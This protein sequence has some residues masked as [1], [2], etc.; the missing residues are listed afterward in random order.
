[1]SIYAHSSW[2]C[3]SRKSGSRPMHASAGWTFRIILQLG[4]LTRCRPPV[5]I[6][7]ALLEASLYL[8]SSCNC[9][10]RRFRSSPCGW[11]RRTGS[12]CGTRA[13]SGSP[14]CPS[15]STWTGSRASRS[16]TPH[17][18]PHLLA[19]PVWGS[20]SAAQG[21]PKIMTSLSSSFKAMHAIICAPY[22]S[23]WLCSRRLT[24][25]FSVGLSLRDAAGV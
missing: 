25:C 23:Y 15:T 7:T 24:A 21:W 22:P 18:C 11:P 9:R 16:A 3:S 20:V 12:S 13:G 8:L 4:S 19:A 2:L 5:S 10:G 14:L 6:L 1:M 17:P